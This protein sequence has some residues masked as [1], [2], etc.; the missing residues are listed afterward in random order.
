MAQGYPDRPIKWIVPWPVGGG[1]DVVARLFSEKVSEKLG[2]PV[3]I[4]NQGGAGGNIGARAAADAKPDGYTMVFAYSGTHSINPHIYK[5]MPFEQGDFAPVIFLTS[6]PQL[7]V[8]NASVQAHSVKDLIAL[9]KASPGK[10][11]FASS[12][13]G[14][15]NHLAGELFT[16][17]AGI[18]LMH[19]PYKGGGPAAMAVLSGEVDM[20]FG[21]PSTLLANIKAG[22]L[23]A[24]AT[25]SGARSISL[26]DIPTISES[27]VPGYDVTSW[28]GVLAPAG[29]PPEA[30]ARLNKAFNEVL[31]DPD[32]RKRLLAIG[33]EPIGGKPEDFSKQ[34]QSELDKWG[35]IVK[36]TGLQIN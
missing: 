20:V 11:K 21:E 31:A 4:F 30:I 25:T 34:I 9:A 12:G 23:R 6:V 2:Q 32:M 5:T 36:Q 29:T 22:K 35:P 10:L 13:N 19:V 33:Y 8:V 14:A 26:P 16:N 24:I 27:G 18:K 1:A 28:N 15:I 3:I 7:L 17:M